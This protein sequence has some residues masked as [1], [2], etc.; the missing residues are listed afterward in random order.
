VYV[1]V[2]QR[3][4]LAAEWQQTAVVAA[5]FMGL[6]LLA[7]LAFGRL[8][9]LS[10]EDSVT[11]GIGFAVRNV[12]LASAIAITLL[13]RIEYAVLRQ[14]S[15]SAGAAGVPDVMRGKTLRDR[16]K[17]WVAERLGQQP[18]EQEISR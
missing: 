8:L 12:G 6:A 4:Q 10:K 17:L 1:M 16:L 7:G 13:N 5:V 15:S 11:V 3:A 9:R 14:Y 2:T 18:L